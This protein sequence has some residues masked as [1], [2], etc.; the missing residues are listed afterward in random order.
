MK[1]V[2]F[3][4]NEGVGWLAIS[5]ELWSNNLSEQHHLKIYIFK[6]SGCKQFNLAIFK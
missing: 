3:R 2:K 5:D 6:V 4:D 1:K